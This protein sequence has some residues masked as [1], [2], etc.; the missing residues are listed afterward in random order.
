[1][2]TLIPERRRLVSG[3]M[4][5]AARLPSDELVTFARLGLCLSPH[6]MQKVHRL[7]EM[8]NDT[9]VSSFEESV[10]AHAHEA[11]VLSYSADATPLTTSEFVRSPD[12]EFVARRRAKRGSEWLVQRLFFIVASGARRA[13]PEE[14]KRMFNKTAWSQLTAYRL[15]AKTA[16]EMGNRDV[17]THHTV[18]DRAVVEPLARHARELRTAVDG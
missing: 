1:M 16:R 12:G 5:S 3:K 13:H 11:I 17:A 18:C 15:L 4:A 2:Y 10:R 6:E 7:C 9:L 8:A 14:P